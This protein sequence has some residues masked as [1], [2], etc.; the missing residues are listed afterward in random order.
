M[1]N[2]YEREGEVKDDVNF[3]VWVFNSNFVILINGILEEE[4]VC[5]WWGGVKMSLICLSILN[6]KCIWDI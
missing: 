1:G 6:L 2:A 3:L 4:L 5:V